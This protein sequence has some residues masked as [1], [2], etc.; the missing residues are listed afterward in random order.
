[1]K[2]SENMVI[3]AGCTELKYQILKIDDVFNKGCAN[4]GWGRQAPQCLQTSRKLV[5][6]REP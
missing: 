4:G 1:M 2:I 5:M 6:Q 3:I